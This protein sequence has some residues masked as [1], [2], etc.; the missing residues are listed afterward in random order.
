MGEN[1]QEVVVMPL[2]FAMM[3]MHSRCHPAAE[4]HGVLLGCVDGG[5]IQISSAYPICHEC[6]NRPLVEAALTITLSSLEE[7]SSNS[8]VGWYTI[9]EIAGDTKPAA[10]LLRLLTG[11]E[12]VA[13]ASDPVLVVLSKQPVQEA[14]AKTSKSYDSTRYLLQAFGKDFGGQYMGKLNA[15]ITSEC[16]TM[17]ILDDLAGQET[18]EDLVDHWSSLE[19]E[20]PNTS[21]ISRHLS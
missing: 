5:K 20:W 21:K 11:L 10:T 8:V 18:I 2:A 4:V 17:K 15:T 3:T 6:P 16:K 14:D 13:S 12:A 1:V 19:T 9:P 7:N